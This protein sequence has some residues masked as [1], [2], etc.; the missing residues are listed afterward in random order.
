MQETAEQTG[1]T[2]SPWRRPSTGRRVSNTWPYFALS[3]TYQLSS[4]QFH[5]VLY[6]I[7]TFYA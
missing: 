1:R 7:I 2:L 6:S 4:D 5:Q 3:S